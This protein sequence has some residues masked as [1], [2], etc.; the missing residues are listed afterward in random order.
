MSK[1]YSSSY[2][3]GDIIKSLY[4]EDQRKNMKGIVM[5]EPCEIRCDFSTLRLK[6]TSRSSF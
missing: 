6:T 4:F 5:C 1:V 2:S 3:F